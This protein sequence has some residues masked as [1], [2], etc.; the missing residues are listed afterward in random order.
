VAE[1]YVVA[2]PIGNLMDMT[3]RAVEVLKTVDLIA[4]EDTRNT[5]KLLNHFDIHTPM[6]SYHDHNRMKA[7][8]QLLGK[9]GEGLS[10]AIVTDAG[11]PIVSDPG[12]ELIRDAW[13]MGH[14][15][16]PVPGAC[17]GITAL[18]G[19]GLNAEQ[20]Y[21]AGFLPR[22]KGDRDAERSRLKELPATIIFYEAPHRIQKTLAAI[23]AAFGDREGCL[24]RE[25]TKK[26]ETFQRGKLS[27]LISYF[28]TNEPRG[29]YVVL[30][31]GRGD[32]EAESVSE[33]TIRSYA[34]E[35]FQN[36]GRMKEVAR[37]LSERFDLSRNDAYR[38]AQEEKDAI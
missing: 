19:A 34:R 18:M 32:I 30:I 7:G 26:F 11:T 16:I 37:S 14:T 10:I 23:Y 17:A 9:L 1:L 20:F 36:G 21:F 35:A 6:M 27:I 22:E 12:Y 28:D 31:E 13:Q 3:F 29:E 4:A 25:L 8:E 38:I 15:V 5:Q 2:T 33:D 24:C